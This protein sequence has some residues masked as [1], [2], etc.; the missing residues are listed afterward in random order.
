MSFI[1]V[2]TLPRQAC[3]K[4]QGKNLDIEEINNCKSIETLKNNIIVVYQQ[5]KIQGRNEEEEWKGEKN[6][7]HDMDFKEFIP[8]K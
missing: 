6:Y 8:Q 4:T 5:L 1:V 3:T 2:L 7:K